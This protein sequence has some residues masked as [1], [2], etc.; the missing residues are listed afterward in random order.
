MLI[1][2]FRARI[3]PRASTVIFCDRSPLAVLPRSRHAA[4]FGLPAELS[5][6]ADFL[7]DAGHFRGERSELIDHGVDGVLQLEHLALGVDG[8]L[9]GEV[10]LGDGRRDVGD[11][12]H[13]RGEVVR[14]Q[15]HVVGEILPGAGHAGHVGL[16]A[17]LSFHTYRSGDVGDLLGK[18]TERVGHVVDRVGE[19]RDLPLGVDLEALRQIAVGDGGHHARDASHLGRQV[20]GH[21]IDVVGEVF[22][23]AGDA[24]H[25][26]LSTELS[27][28]AYLARN[29]RHFG[30]E[31]IELI[32]HGVDRVLQLEHLA[33]GIDGDLLGEVAVGD[34]G[35]H[36]RDVAHLTGQV[37]SHEI[38]VVGEVLP[39]AAHALHVRLPAELS[40]GADFLGDAGHFGGE[41]VQRVHHRVDGV[42][43]LQHFALGVDGDLLGEVASRDGGRHFGDVAHLRREVIGELVHVVGEV[44][45]D[46]GRVGNGGLSTE[47]SVGAYFLGDAGNLGRERAQL[48]DHRVDGR[49]DAQEL[50]FDRLAFDLQRHL[51]REVAVG[52]GADD[53][54]D[55]GRRLDQVA[56]ERVDGV[57][58][59]GPAA[60]HV[61]ER[62]TLGHSTLPTDDALDAH[63]LADHRFVHAHH[64]IERTSE[65]RHDAALT[66]E[67]KAS[68][69]I[70][71][72]DGVE[73]V[74]QLRQ[75]GL[76]YQS[77]ASIRVGARL[78]LGLVVGP[79][80]LLG[81]GDELLAVGLQ[82][83]L[84]M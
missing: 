79:P 22:P 9:L 26:S 45:P 7:G 42:F 55:L 3:S 38:D 6:G 71:E 61:A 1:V 70:A 25:Q 14:E 75:V 47:L 66:V 44:A 23:R 43:H 60:A 2:F 74:E 81:V 52:D 53:A 16:G 72:R 59:G 13:L 57:E 33:L 37:R 77:V 8:D 35:R 10:A 83:A 36:E 84:L 82:N 49:A 17:E 34:G 56:D 15:V 5:F 40:V 68:R 50:S 51:L 28:G 21:E 30:G 54:G 76:S 64:V 12:A 31:R 67:G 24:A 41:G 4:H 65:R 32:D 11:V 63:H 19:C 48:I 69:K 20:G 18:D 27:F 73:G 62:S 39:D 46:A 78:A 29:A 80:G 58:A